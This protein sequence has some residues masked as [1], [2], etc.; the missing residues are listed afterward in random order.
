[1][2]SPATTDERRDLLVERLFEAT[3]GTFDLLT[4]YIG[5][6]LGLYRTLAEEG[7]S[8]PGELARAAGIHERYAREWLEQQ[9]MSGILEVDDPDAGADERRY[10]LRRGTRSLSSE[11]RA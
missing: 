3:L 2:A 9:A 1:M 10:T 6:R 4:V 5:D 8:T 7:A 11:R